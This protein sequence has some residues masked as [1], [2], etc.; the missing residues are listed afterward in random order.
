MICLWM[1][2]GSMLFW[3]LH[4]LHCASVH[5]GKTYTSASI[6]EKQ[7]DDDSIV[8]KG[9]NYCASSIPEL[10]QVYMASQN[11]HYEIQ[12]PPKTLV[13]LASTGNSVLGK[14]THVN[15]FPPLTLEIPCDPVPTTFSI[16][17]KGIS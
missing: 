6:K 9:E 7:K 4:N 11:G 1:L 10:V 17:L 15:T 13:G 16:S 3:V 12:R 14:V 2:C 5:P 8:A